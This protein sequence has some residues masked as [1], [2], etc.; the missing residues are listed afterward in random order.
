MWWSSQKSRNFLTVNWVPLSVM[1]EFGTPKRWMMLVKNA[2]TYSDL[3][4]FRG[5]T[6]IHLENLSIATSRCVKPPGC[7]LQG[8]D[9]VQT[10]HS[11]RLGDGYCLQSL[12]GQVGLPCVELTPLTG[13]Y[14]PS[15]VSHRGW[16]VET[17]SED[18]SNEGSRRCVV[19]ACPRV[20][21]LQ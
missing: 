5:R 3:M 12:R 6:S 19:T 16:P 21:F 11:K 2:T 9:E 4:L 8:T 10:P 14:N 18:I 17:L 15:G 20:Y 1:M 13:A 7:L